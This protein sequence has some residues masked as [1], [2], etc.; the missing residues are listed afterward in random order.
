MKRLLILPLAFAAAV[1]VQA[2]PASVTGTWTVAANIS[3]SQSEQTCDFTQKETELTGTCKSDRGS[4]TITGKVDGT[5]VTWQFN[6]QYEGQT[7]TPVY[8]GKLESADKIAGSVDVQ[9]MGVGGEFTAAR[10]K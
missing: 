5:A 10:V 4:V 6:T 8:S 1:A 3:G 2:Q 7:L 9:G